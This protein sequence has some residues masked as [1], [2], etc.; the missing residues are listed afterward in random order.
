MKTLTKE[1]LA[2]MLNGRQ[3]TEEITRQE[4]EQ[5]KESG[6]VVVY[7][8]SDDLCEFE[9]AIQE[10]MGAWEGTDLFVDKDGVMKQCE[11]NY[12]DGDCGLCQRLE[13]ARH[14][15]VFWDSEGY[16]WAYATDIPHATFEIFEDEN[17]YCRGIVFDIKDL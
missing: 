8:A 4:A 9:G 15:Q 13:S 5:A 11:N 12:C 6:L 3:Y 10:E 17:K 7:G 16:S 14:L 1:E 2:E